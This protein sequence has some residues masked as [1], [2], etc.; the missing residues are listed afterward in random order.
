ME[1]Q[2]NYIAPVSFLMAQGLLDTHVCSSCFGHLISHLTNEGV[3]V[4]CASCGP[5]TR[6]YVSKR[7]AERRRQESM[8]E[9]IEAQQVLKNVIPSP[10]SG[11]SVTQLMRE[12]GY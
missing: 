5:A 4:T 7:Y 1:T 2:D 10:N 3:V 8:A 11:K 12:L 6:G 9:K